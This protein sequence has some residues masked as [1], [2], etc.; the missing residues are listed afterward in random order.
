MTIDTNQDLSK[1]EKHSPHWTYQF[2]DLTQIEAGQLI[3]PAK[4]DSEAGR[5]FAAL[6]LIRTDL[7]FAL[8]CLKEADK[9]GLPDSANIH[10]RALI[11]SAVVAY[12]RPFMTGVRKIRLDG[13]FFTG[14]GEGFNIDLHTYLIAVRNKH[15]AHSVNEFERCEATAVM[16][17]TNDQTEWRAAGVGFTEY[18]VIGLSRSIVEQAIDQIS[19][20]VTVLAA[21]LDRRRLELYEA[22]RAQYERDGKWEMAPMFNVPSR[23]NAPNRRA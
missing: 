3:V 8:E 1:G 18:S 19:N 20:M 9:L 17:G 23:K 4:I 13:T 22:F 10:S 14:A 12:A 2:V 6:Q 16:V 21:D 5:E 7:S 11:F 15:V